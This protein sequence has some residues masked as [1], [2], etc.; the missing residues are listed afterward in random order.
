MIPNNFNVSTFM[1]DGVVSGA[2]GT[3]GDNVKGDR[4]S[5]NKS[6]Q[7]LPSSLEYS[8]C[9]DTLYYRSQ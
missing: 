7:A 3:N 5:A 6:S 9:A 1:C 2:D 4:A 8:S